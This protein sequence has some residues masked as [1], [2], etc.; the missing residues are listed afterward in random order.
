MAWIDDAAAAAAAKVSSTLGDR[1]PTEDELKDALKD[2]MQNAAPGD[3]PDV[4]PVKVNLR[5]DAYDALLEIASI[6]NTDLT[7]A[8]HQCIFTELAVAQSKKSGPI[9]KIRSR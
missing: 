7:T 5:R 2:A 1:S 4:V 9:S 6:Y 3:K 8:L